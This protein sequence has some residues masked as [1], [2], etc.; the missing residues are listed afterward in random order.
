[1][2]NLNPGIYDVTIRRDDTVIAE[3]RGNSIVVGGSPVA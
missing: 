1:M 2:T 3:F